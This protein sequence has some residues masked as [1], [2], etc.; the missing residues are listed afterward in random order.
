VELDLRKANEAHRKAVEDDRRRA[1]E[2][3]RR[4]TEED[5]RRAEQEQAEARKRERR[6]RERHE[7]ERRQRQDSTITGVRPSLEDVLPDLR[8]KMGSAAVLRGNDVPKIL[9]RF[10]N[11]NGSR[12]RTCGLSRISPK[13]GCG[14]CVPSTARLGP[15]SR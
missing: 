1:E 7:W 8:G 5:R 12:W 2:E 9:F 6:E 11:S 10:S 13:S 15:A 4:V 3:H 14:L